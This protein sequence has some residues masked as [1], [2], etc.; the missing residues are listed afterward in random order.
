MS[1]QVPDKEVLDDLKRITET[2]GIN[3][4]N[5]WLRNLVAETI[6]F[7]NGNDSVISSHC[8]ITWSPETGSI[9]FQEY[10]PARHIL[11]LI[12]FDSAKEW[13][14][15]S[16]I[17]SDNCIEDVDNIMKIIIESG[18]LKKLIVEKLIELGIF[19]K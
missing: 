15:W 19:C 2:N 9:H 18:Q 6:S 17:S 12:I 16:G 8:L 13:I 7:A 3:I 10:Q 5:W 11:S 4:S 1:K 14:E